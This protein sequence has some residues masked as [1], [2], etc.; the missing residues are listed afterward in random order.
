MHCQWSLNLIYVTHT[1]KR[2]FQRNKLHTSSNGVLHCCPLKNNIGSLP[3]LFTKKKASLTMKLIA[4]F[5]Y[6]KTVK[7]ARDLS[8][9]AQALHAYYQFVKTMIWHGISFRQSRGLNPRAFRSLIKKKSRMVNWHT[10]LPVFVWINY[11][12]WLMHDGYLRVKNEKEAS[13]KMEFVS[14]QGR[15]NAGSHI[16]NVHRWNKRLA[17]KNTEG[18]NSNNIRPL[19]P[20]TRESR[21]IWHSTYLAHRRSTLS[22][23]NIY[24]YGNAHSE[25]S[26]HFPWNALD[27]ATLLAES[28]TSLR[29]SFINQ[30]ACKPNI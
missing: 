18:F 26:Q 20:L 14:V 24:W 22:S 23:V 16:T 30:Q 19:S 6:L 2:Y 29:N 4:T 21:N 17:N 27:T 11:Y 28:E 1:F 13:F 12:K 10:A 15:W 25:R 7:T 5:F 9:C 8:P 3:T